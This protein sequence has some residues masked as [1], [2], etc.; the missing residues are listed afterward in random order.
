MSHDDDAIAIVGLSC[1][2]P[3][4]ADR[5][6]LW[7]LLRDGVDAVRPVPRTRIG[8]WD[9]DPATLPPAGFIDGVAEFDADFFGVAPAEA[10]AMDPQQRLA[11]ELAWEGLEDAGHDPRRWRD[12]EVGVFV[13]I[14]DG[15]Y[16]ALLEAA[17]HGALSSAPAGAARNLGASRISQ[18]FGFQGLSLAVDS[19]A[20]SSLVA[21]H[22]A[23]ESLR[24]EE[25][26]LALAGG[27]S[28]ILAPRTA[29]PAGGGRASGAGD[30]LDVP[31]GETALGEG[32]AIVVLKR[33]ANAVADGDRIH[34]VIRG[35]AVSSG[36]GVAGVTSPVAA[37]ERVIR[38]A[39]ARA[40]L[41]PGEIGYVELDGSASRIGGSI[42][43]AALERVYGAERPAGEP[44]SVG[45][46]GANIGHLRAAAGIA[47]LIKVAL[48]LDRRE[49]VAS[50]H[51]EQPGPGIALGPRGMRVVR[52]H[53]PWPAD[54][55]LAAGVSSFD[56]DATNCHMLL[57]AAPQPAARSAPTGGRPRAGVVPWVLSGHDEAALRAQASRLKA[58]V[59]ARTELEPADVGW[60]LATTR[61]RLGRRAVV[62]GSDRE[63]LLGRLGAV[64]AGDPSAGVAVAS[65]AV[66]ESSAAA[67]GKVAFVF[68]GQGSQWLGMALELWDASAVFAERMEVC[69]AALRPF[70]DWD[71]RDVLSG[72]PGAP[73]L[74]RTDVVQPASFALFV[75]LAAL[76]R[77][78]GVEPSVVIGHSQGEIAAAH[79][80]GALTLQDAA[81]VVALR[82]RLLAQVT[83]AMASLSLTASEVRERIRRS[84]TGLVVGAHNGPRTTVVSGD[85][86]AVRELVAACEAAGERARTVA[87]EYPAHSPAIEAIRERLLEDLA[88]VAPMAATIPILSTT[89][90]GLIDGAAM[91]AAHWYRNEREP[92]RFEDATRAA[93]DDGV[94]TFI[95]IS[96]HPVLAW[97]LRETVEDATADRDAAGVIGT[98]RRGEGGLERFMTSVGQAHVVGVEIDW[99]ALFRPDDPRRVDLP[100]YAFGRRRFWA[101]EQPMLPQ[102][103]RVGSAAGLARLTGAERD[104]KLLELV[105]AEAATVLGGDPDGAVQ[106][107]RAFREM[108]FDSLA[109]VDLRVRLMAVTG[110]QLPATLAFDHPT[111]AAVAALLGTLLA[112]GERQQRAVRPARVRADEPI[113]I[114][115]M[116]CRY[117]G[118]VASAQDLWDLVAA[119]VDAIGP[120]PTDR[121]WDLDRLYDPDPDRAGHSYV[122]AGGFLYDAADFDAGFFSIA[123]REASAMDPQQRIVLEVAWAALE[124][125]AIDP[126]TLR[127]SPTGVFA[128]ISLQDYG[129]I[130]PGVATEYEGLRLTGCLTSV[131]SG[132]VSYA[133]GLQGPAVTV[134]T[135]CSSSL[136]SLHLACQ[137]LRA[138]ECSLALAGGVTVMSS[139]GMFVEFSRQRGL[140]EDGRSKPFAAAADGANWAEGAGVLV[141]ERLSDA[142][143]LG[144]RVLAIVRG[145]ATNQDGASNGL[146]APNGPSQ[147]QVI[148][149]ALANAGVAPGDVDAV[150]AH[151]TG[152]RL[153]DPIEAQALMATY[154]QKRSGGPLRLGSIKSNIGH[155]QAAAGVAGVIKMVMAMREEVLP[156]TLHV[157]EPTPHV[158]WSAGEVALLTEA[159]PW[160]RS[161][162]PRR[163]GVSSFG[164]SGT[165]AHVVLEEAPAELLDVPAAH[166]G[167]PAG[168]LAA[169]AGAAAT[170]GLAARDGAAGPLAVP[171]LLSARTEEAL[172]EQARRLRAHVAARPGLARADVGWSLAA[173]RARLERRAVVAGAEHESLLAGL[174]A[175]AA[176]E[177]LD[178][179][180]VGH[181]DVPAKVAFVFPGQGSQ[182]LG[183]ALEL[184][185]SSAVFA[186]RMDACA[187]ALHEFVEWDLGEV[188]R[189]APGA[190]ALER[191]DVVQPAS[192]A[193]FVSLA[194][195]W[196][197][198]GVEPAVVVGH[199]QG[200]IAAAHVAGA[201]SLRD[202]A[203]VAALRSRA[204]VSLSG[205]G[206]MLSV[207]ASAAQVRVRIARWEGALWLASYNSPRSTVVS[208]DPGA[209]GE[210]LAE[211]EA[212][213]VRSR[214][215]AVDYASHSAQ[216]DAIR[217]RLVE[218]LAPLAPMSGAVPMLSTTTAT[219]VDGATL[220]A[221]HWFR[222]L[223]DPVR[224]EQATRALLDDAITAFVECSPHPV[225][226][227]AVQ[228]TIDEAAGDPERIAVV[229]SLRRGE[230]TMARF[231]Q[232]AGEAHAGGVEVDWA[233]AFARSGPRRVELP[234]YPFQRTR[235]WVAPRAGAP[236]ATRSLAAAGLQAAEHPL[237]GAAVALAGR[238]GCILTARLSAGAHPWLADHMLHDEVLLPASAFAELA[239]RA[240]EEVGCATVEELVVAAPLVLREETDAQLQVTVGEPT[241]GGR[242]SFDVHARLDA[243]PDGWVRHA[244]GTVGAGA[245]VPHD[246]PAAWPPPG[247]RAVDVDG[248]YDRLAEQGFAYGPA[249][250]AVRSA[251][252][253]GDEAFSEVAVSE[254]QAADAVRFAVHPVLLDAALHAAL[255]Q[256][257]AAGSQLAFSWTGVRV[258]QRGALALRVRVAPVGADVLRLTATDERGGLVV[259]VDAIAMRAVGTRSHAGGHGAL[260]ALYRVSW[261][262]GPPGSANGA[263]ARLVVLGDVELPGAQAFEDLAALAAHGAGPG[264]VV[265][266]APADAV[267]ALALLQEI[268]AEPRLGEARLAVLTPRAAAVIDGEAP[269]PTTAAIRGLIR[270]AQSEHPRRFVSVDADAVGGLA[271]A[272]ASGEPE[273]AVRDGAVLVPRLARAR[274]DATPLGAWR[275]VPE[276]SGALIGARAVPGDGD[277]PLGSG[278]V[279]IAVRAAG[280]SFGDIRTALGAEAGAEQPLGME[281]A[282]VIVEVGPGASGLA[283][284]DRVLG[285]ISGAFGPLAVADAHALVRMPG[286]WS[287]VQAAAVPV[288]QV[289]ARHALVDLARLRPGERV[290]IHAAT[291]GV[292]SAAVRLAQLLGAEVFATASPSK[293]SA[294]R[295][296]G[297][298]DAHLASSRS[299]AFGERFAA[300]SGGAGM[301]VVLNC[302]SGGLVDTSL[303]LLAP[304][305]R[306]VE[307][308]AP[309]APTGGVAERFA[310][311]DLLG[312]GTRR[313]G[314]LLA[315]VVGQLRRE[316]LVAPPV[317]VW[318]VRRGSEALRFVSQARHVGK[319]VL[320]VP[321]ALDPAGTVL[322]T[323]GTAGLGALVA[324]HLA[325]EHGVRHVLL[326]S[327]RGGDADCA[328]ELQ[329]RLAELGC[330]AT[331]A[332]CDVSDRAAL[333]ELLAT[334]GDDRPLTAVVHAATTSANAMVESLDRAALDGVMATK[335]GGARWL[336]ELTAGLDLAAF[337]LFSSVA[338]TFGHPG[339]GNYAAANAY[340]DA[341]AQRR[342]AAGL[343]ATSV[344]W[345]LWKDAGGMAGRLSR[346]DVEVLEE[347]TGERELPVAQGLALL[348]AALD[349]RE[350]A[351]V[352]VALDLGTLRAHARAG[353]LPAL[354][355]DLVRAPARR[356]TGRAATGGTF[357]RELAA[358][359][360]D[361]RHGLVLALVR[362]QAAASLGHASADDVPPDRSFKELG[363]DSLGSIVLRNR[364]AQVTGLRLSSTAVFDHPTPLAMATFLR[365]EAESQASAGASLAPDETGVGT[366]PGGFAGAEAPGAVANGVGLPTVAVP[367]A[368]SGVAHRRPAPR[369]ARADRRYGGAMLGSVARAVRILRLH[370]WELEMR[371]RLARVNCRFV[372][373][374][375][376][377]PRFDEL[378]QIAFDSIG[379]GHGSLTLRIGRDCRFGRGLTIDL[380]THVDGVIEIGDGCHFQHR[381][382]LQPWG[383]AIRLARKVQVRD[384]AELKSK[385]EFVV[386]AESVIARNV[387][388]HCHER[389]E[390]ADRVSLAERVTVMDSDRTHDGTDTHVVR[391]AVVSSPVLVETNVFVGTNAIILRGSHIGRN[392]MIAAGAV[393]TGGDYPAR[394]L[395]AGVPAQPVRPLAPDEPPPG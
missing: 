155:A 362:A 25:C 308:G 324:E 134:D 380:W 192:F 262:P 14:A 173:G 68:P 127:G 116:S 227:W 131:I 204:L 41:D 198:L 280:V 32:G 358:V 289:T 123:P 169:P 393:L 6:A 225:L 258:H 214:M 217:D 51:A 195:L 235:F 108:G 24:S 263:P 153:G 52:E 4:A 91:G 264:T 352:A 75:S 64:A 180:A 311:V 314:E 381:I 152:T 2:L 205:A 350:P 37:R 392:A 167:A 306:F 213:G 355:R 143:R 379:E 246:L 239:L 269:D 346:R 343:P 373:E 183:M 351:L 73:R 114:V 369:L 182:W 36:M 70:V 237:L 232:S 141:V 85:A 84:G 331:L 255:A 290:L 191:M 184:W 44:L 367:N 250:Q 199:S 174:G 54:A 248:L 187:A 261:V 148:R 210:L 357:V 368:G 231:L 34:C 349:H 186:G 115:G 216:I 149:Q 13:G 69:S 40:R 345:G 247:A 294:L 67:P 157:D 286:G 122:R 163:A 224:F 296:V 50:L 334:I 233:A 45:S 317:S 252:L 226:T 159:V 193:V 240:G 12:G 275:L 303:D 344:A 71:L 313:L 222:N 320:T 375:D 347:A 140:A 341:L 256:R 101:G 189:G 394:Y 293:W 177:P 274:G 178:G 338:G 125:A 277:R 203:R 243:D 271:Q 340:L 132:R 387:T 81:R 23:C 62:V 202:A 208:G 390:L 26:L 145:T 55:G 333:A 342:R 175:V 11:L 360:A 365:A 200:E 374:I 59:E 166:T 279:R 96:P 83:G 27:V 282:G 305:G 128:G 364:I 74:D 211:C 291:G 287:F 124:D 5:P 60:S 7:R 215:I 321:R 133:L 98:L 130:L 154:G 172:R 117:P 194:A 359:S 79:V 295:A 326:V 89:T 301:D 385:G 176:G 135:A 103:P 100:P 389:I 179:V 156:A 21:V 284:G 110:L 120:F 316:E 310:R 348:S 35:S 57:S 63:T 65:A 139:P 190:P 238:D 161:A 144:H 188:L 251:W 17:G 43:A 219:L 253:L 66:P 58:H 95:E 356:A 158:D 15:E 337:V 168:E 136:V 53:G 315:E 30:A 49:L 249:L 285:F 259:T 270:S 376:G 28:L 105:L 288:A 104:A 121:G 267:A 300:S 332:S 162:R 309:E 366:L 265:V 76:W 241:A 102:V 56:A 111:P 391:Q 18:F 228:E 87:I 297:L 223:R 245:T 94:T 221:E 112:G 244:T 395:H 234:T 302:L 354:L 318:D 22:L 48:C 197:S 325:R 361:E 126:K 218:D 272:V 377:T 260:D 276:R 42:E 383:G 236:A 20:S 335:S 129:S 93:I 181:A 298:D 254:E 299:R 113:A 209:L 151:G 137:A 138:G 220:D 99:D 328:R 278:E 80:A 3:L 39:L 171:W 160:P 283:A 31:A 88:P 142:R 230:G 229:G 273:V 47:G 107:Q 242:R 150:E 77:S 378:P 86:A 268:L 329:T 384:G 170:E 92:V 10:V 382:R 307:L 353:T 46:I 292:G 185:D 147:E 61:A 106:A 312:L 388:V 372:L 327:R 109:S 38:A 97:A 9:G 164:I 281:G 165:N 118:G 146:A 72:A 33:L 119:G 16:A 1:R 339:Q 386:G 201:L 266:A 330:A 323:G 78:V 82:A 304:G 206:G 207:F 363:F 319:V 90:A 257:E 29:R 8:A 371:A 212:A 336:D 322:V 19:G 196:R 370:A